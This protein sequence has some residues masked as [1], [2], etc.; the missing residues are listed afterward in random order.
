MSP[1]QDPPLPTQKEADELAEEMRTRADGVHRT[2]ATV[3]V[4]ELLEIV[5]RVPAQPARQLWELITELEIE[6]FG[7]CQ[8]TAKWEQRAR[9]ERGLP[10]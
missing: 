7:D 6:A 3:I 5:P 10:A 2:A 4:A 9:A 1:R 8:I